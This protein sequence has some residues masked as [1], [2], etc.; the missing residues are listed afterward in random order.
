MQAWL[1]R[2][3]GRESVAKRHRVFGL[4]IALVLAAGV[5][6]IV[7]TGA[8]SAGTGIVRS[9]VNANGGVYW[10][11]KPDWNTPIKVS[12]HG[13]YNGDRVE[14]EC[15]VRGGTVPPYD[16]NPLWYQAKIVSGFGIGS[17]LVNDH[18]IDTGTNVPNQPVEGVPGCGSSPVVVNAFYNRTAAI[19]WALA[20]AKDPQAYGAMCTWFA[21]NVLWAGGFPKTAVWTNQGHYG[22]APG[23]KDAWWLP[24]FLPYLRAHAST[25]TIDITSD[26]KT[27]AVPQ[28][29]PGDLILYDWGNGEGISHVAFVVDIASGQ[30]PEVA[31]MG[32]YDFGILDAAV[33]KVVHVRSSYVKRGWTYSAVHH[34]WLQKKYPHVKAYLL[35]IN[36]GYFVPSF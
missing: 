27:N 14:L 21:S 2:G 17:G 19:N 28:A 7:S 33:N 34:E 31:E 24:S 10:R 4:L 13:V 1:F 9:V 25:T 11:A 35:H 20:H 16:N 6:G 22:S 15:Y 30:Y 26:F 18:F 12:R 23:T 32:Q 8:A 36:G 3:Q 5:F 29:E